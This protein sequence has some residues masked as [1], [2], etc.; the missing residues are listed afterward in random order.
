M[1]MDIWDTAGQEKYRS[2]LTLYYKNSDVILMV[3][4][5]SRPETFETVDFWAGQIEEN[6]ETKPSV[7]L[8]GNK[9]DLRNQR[10]LIPDEKIK[11][12]AKSKGW[13]FF[14][15]SAL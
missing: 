1:S 8:I 11:S 3:F 6:C 13:Y 9:Y 14:Y 7:I 5:L 12:Y 10:K 15:A 4:D 2:L